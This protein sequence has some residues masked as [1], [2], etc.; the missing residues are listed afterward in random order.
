LLRNGREALLIPRYLDLL[1]LLVE[2]RNEAVHRREILDVVWNDVVVT[3]GSVSQAVRILRRTL[4]DDP[5]RPAFIRTIPRHGYR[6]VHA[7]VVEEPDDAPLEEPAPESAEANHDEERMSRAVAVLLQP[8]HQVDEDAR[9]EA[10]ETLHQLGTADA[11]GRI[12]ALDGHETARAWLRDT[13]WD[14]PGAGQ[15][16]LLGAPGGMT[17]A[18]ILFGLR[19]RRTVRLAGRRFASAVA[20]AAVTGVIAGLLGGLLLRFG[21]GSIADNRVL[22]ALPLVGALIGAVGAIGVGAGLAAAEG[23]IRSH[24]VVTLTLL[25]AVGGGAIG[26]TAHGLGSLV[27]EGLFARDLKPLAGGFEGLVLGAAIGLG[28][29]LATPALEGGMATP[30]GLARLAAVA[31]A[32]IAAAIAAGLLASAG[33]YLGAMSLDFMARSF[34]GAQLRLDPLARMLGETSPG[35]LTRIVISLFEGLMFGAGVVFGLTRRPR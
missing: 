23:S 15:V 20:G 2:R 27:L 33:S 24:R 8:K 28:Y 10:A 17:A 9:R 26:L 6:F 12:D 21:P 18:R 1:L 5:R 7:E 22:F 35:P 14:V 25:G 19:L 30:H 13:R 32:A 4:G 34:P 3:D 29:A 11:L 16:P 31:S